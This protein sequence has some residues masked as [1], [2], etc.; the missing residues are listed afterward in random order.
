M[1]YAV[2]IQTAGSIDIFN[3]VVDLLPD[4]DPEGLLL[5]VAGQGERGVA[6]LSVWRWK[7]DADRF[8]AEQHA[9]ALAKVLGAPPP[10]PD[11]MVEFEATDVLVTE[12]AS[13]A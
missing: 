4:T 12:P 2:F 7:E 1:T 5:R 10:R 13:S 11:T 8:F 3:Q 9:P 6:V